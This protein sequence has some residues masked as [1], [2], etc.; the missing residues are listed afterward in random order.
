MRLASSRASGFFLSAL[1][2]SSRFMCVHW[3]FQ[4]WSWGL[5]AMG[6]AVSIH[7]ALI[8]GAGGCSPDAW[9]PAS[10]FLRAGANQM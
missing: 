3:L 4:A 10:V 5:Y 8:V 9:S 1:L 2:R 6:E 7:L